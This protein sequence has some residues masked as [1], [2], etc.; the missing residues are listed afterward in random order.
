MSKEHT[1][2]QKKI[3]ET[4][5]SWRSELFWLLCNPLYTLYTIQLSQVR[6]H[7]MTLLKHVMMV[8]LNNIFLFFHF[9]Y[10]VFEKVLANKEPHSS[11]QCFVSRSLQ[12]ADNSQSIVTA[13]LHTYTVYFSSIFYD[14]TKKRGGWQYL[15]NWHNQEGQWLTFF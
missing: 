12:V 1:G 2:M 11:V 15:I 9:S 5:L 10:L 14:I 6:R 3:V 13:H 7:H 4:N 8:R